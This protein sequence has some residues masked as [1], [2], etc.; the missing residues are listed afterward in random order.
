VA[1]GDG[2]AEGGDRVW[3]GDVETVR[4]AADRLGQRLQAL[5]APG[6]DNDLPT[7]SG[8]EARRRFAN[9]ARGSGDHRGLHRPPI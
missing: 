8:E 1:L 5:E 2:G 4:L 7:V 6:A 3:I 9:S